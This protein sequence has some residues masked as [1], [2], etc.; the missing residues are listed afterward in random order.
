ME[1]RI[2]LIIQGEDRASSVLAGAAGNANRSMSM[3]QKAGSKLLTGFLAY[4]AITGVFHLVGGAV[5]MIGD[6][7]AATASEGMEFN[8]TISAIGA[9]SRA[10]TEDL[11]KL[12]TLANQL[13]KDTVFTSNEAAEAIKELTK[14]G[15]STEI[16]LNGAAEAAVNLAAAG[17]LDLAPAAEIMARALN[18][19]NLGG[20]K[21]AWVADILT[22]AANTS[23]TSVENIGAAMKFASA[24]MEGLTNANYSSEAAFVDLATAIAAMSNMGIDASM[25]GTG[26]SRILE[27]LTPNSE[28]AAT[29]MKEMGISFFDAKGD[30]IGLKA[31]VDVLHGGL[32]GL[33]QEDQATKLEKIFG[34]RGKNAVQALMNAIYE[35]DKSWDDMR[36][37]IVETNLAVDT[38]AIKL[39]NLAGSV[40]FLKGTISSFRLEIWTAQVE[41]ALQPATERITAMFNTLITKAQDPQFQ[42]AI[43][44]IANTLSVTLIGA[45]DIIE[46]RLVGFMEA[47]SKP[48]TAIAIRDLGFAFGNL[49]AAIM[50]EKAPVDPTKGLGAIRGFTDYMSTD[51]PVTAKTYS[52]DLATGI[53]ALAKAITTLADTKRGFDAFMVSFNHFAS[54][55]YEQSNLPGFKVWFDKQIEEGT[56]WNDKMLEKITGWIDNK[57]TPE[58]NRGLGEMY[59]AWIKDWQKLNTWWTDTFL[60]ENAKTYDGW[61]VQTIVGAF[62]L[63]WADMKTNWETSWRTLNTWLE[64]NW[65]AELTESIG[66]ISVKDAAILVADTAIKGLTGGLLSG[67][68]DVKATAK[69]LA[70]AAVEVWRFIW[71]SRSPSRVF[72]DIGYTAPQGAALG[73]KSGEKMVIGAAVDLAKGAMDTIMGVFGKMTPELREKTS[74]IARLIQD[75]FG[76]VD[77]GLGSMTALQ[78]YKPGL[79]RDTVVLFANDMFGVVETIQAV[80]LKFS[81]DGVK[82]AAEWATSANTV[83]GLIVGGVDALV[84]MRDVT[85]RGLTRDM[86]LQF[87]KDIFG[88]VETIQAVVDGFSSDGVKAAAEWATSAGTIV[89]II[90]GGIDALV[91][92]T[93]YKIGPVRENVVRFAQDIAQ[94]VH[95]IR[96]TSWDFEQEGVEAAAVFAEAVGRIVSPIVGAV[97]AFTALRDYKGILPWMLDMLGADIR[98]AIIKME[99]L[100]NQFSVEGVEAAAT[101]ADAT[102]RILAPIATAVE[103]FTKVNDYKG[104][105]PAAMKLL[106]SDMMGTVGH[107]IALSKYADTEGAAAAADFADASGRIFAGVSAGIETISAVNES[108]A[109]DAGKLKGVLA[110][111]QSILTQ[112]TEMAKAQGVQGGESFVSNWMERMLAMKAEFFSFFGSYLEDAR[113]NA[114]APAYAA[115]TDQAAGA[116]AEA[117]RAWSAAFAQNVTVDTGYN[118][119]STGGG[120]RGGTPDGHQPFFTN[121]GG[122]NGGGGNLTVNFNGM[123]LPETVNRV[124]TAVKRQNGFQG[125]VNRTYGTKKR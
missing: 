116:G 46:P 70:E 45:I 123:S 88:V 99:D 114:L 21:A 106:A 2:R 105:A 19:F 49:F 23:A 7:L 3:L 8:R 112:A 28:K 66:K 75:I 1:K 39:D 43:Q 85:T 38:A 63:Q 65:W 31:A 48:E 50:G 79:L 103:T 22:G 104:V 53:T 111:V 55:D 12:R 47:L 109:L 32:E 73:M 115:M 82:A 60:T 27:G 110:D 86:V 95:I 80:V 10:S 58:I 61:V 59:D 30:F 14:A 96:E 25:A 118:T 57:L 101:F 89:G 13:G 117:G 20:E 100:A 64:T 34:V 6:Q 108:K 56:T 72:T 77:A 92:L 124:N 5:G 51:K 107:L 26:L 125:V 119:T 102:G 84:H 83:L 81:K 33:T 71:K 76:A 69:I 15:V 74:D 68:E 87:S 52:M 18:G 36:G 35:G 91:K 16:I 78:E 11:G 41:Q 42:G 90:S 62:D 24:N 98:L 4:K 9:I 29:M 120:N 40:E 93:T 44:N 113:N 67:L 122:G 94:V 121:G 17:E 37:E 97:E 54:G